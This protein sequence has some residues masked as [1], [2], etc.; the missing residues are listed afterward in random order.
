LSYSALQFCPTSLFAQIAEIH[1]YARGIWPESNWWPGHNSNDVFGKLRTESIY[2]AKFGGF[3][4]D[5]FELGGNFGYMNHFEPSRHN[6]ILAANAAA[7]IS[8][9]SIRGLLWEATGD[10]NFAAQQFLGRGVTPYVAAGVGR[11]ILPAEAT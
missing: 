3:V 9:Q 10:Y 2:G 4:T 11:C 8:P 1:P 6:D 5:K 7:G